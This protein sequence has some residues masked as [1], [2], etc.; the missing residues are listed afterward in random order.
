MKIP[1]VRNEERSNNQHGNIIRYG[2]NA[3][4]TQITTNVELLFKLRTIDMVNG[5]LIAVAPSI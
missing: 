1:I 2:S 3:R 5:M 4:K